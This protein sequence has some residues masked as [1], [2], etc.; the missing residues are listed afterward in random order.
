MTSYCRQDNNIFFLNRLRHFAEATWSPTLG[1][2]SVWRAAAGCWKR[3]DWRG[4]VQS[5]SVRPGPRCHPA[6][7]H[8]PPEQEKLFSFQFS[9][10]KHCFGAGAGRSRNF[11]AARESTILCSKSEK[12]T[13]NPA[14]LKQ[15]L[16]K[17]SF[18]FH[19]QHLTNL[20]WT[21]LPVLRAGF[22]ALE[23]TSSFSM[24][25]LHH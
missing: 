8:W 14:N 20:V 10:D 16:F 6:R 15:I 17:N 2:T 5:H 11:K 24:S 3:R 4:S 7:T 13:L 9:C 21:K 12:N 23:K 19:F 18:Y 22:G 1:S 25:F